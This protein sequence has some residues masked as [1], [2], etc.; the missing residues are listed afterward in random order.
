[1]NPNCYTLF[2]NHSGHSC[3]SKYGISLKRNDDALLL[4]GIN[5]IRHYISTPK[6]ILEDNP[7]KELLQELFYDEKGPWIGLNPQR[8]EAHLYRCFITESERYILGNSGEESSVV[9][10]MI[11]APGNVNVRVLGQTC[12]ILTRV[13]D[14]KQY[15]L[16]ATNSYAAIALDSPDSQRVTYLEYYKGGFTVS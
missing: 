16:I 9:Y 14:Q 10:I 3:Y 12:S 13:W 7:S 2:V 6:H 8:N 15:V 11:E 1:M 4:N 5:K